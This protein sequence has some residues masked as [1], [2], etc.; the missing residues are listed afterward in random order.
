MNA[1]EI[2]EATKHE[3]LNGTSV[4]YLGTNSK[5]CIAV[6]PTK[7][8]GVKRLLCRHDYQQGIVFSFTGGQLTGQGYTMS[9]V[10]VK[11]GRVKSETF[12]PYK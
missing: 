6:L 2:E 10:C 3:S 1:N 12:I 4:P 9:T 11:C 7:A 5:F 8:G